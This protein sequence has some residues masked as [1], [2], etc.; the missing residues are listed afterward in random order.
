MHAK[1]ARPAAA[2]AIPKV[3]KLFA[4]IYA[5]DVNIIATVP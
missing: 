5:T 4:K 1:C 2:V 3:A